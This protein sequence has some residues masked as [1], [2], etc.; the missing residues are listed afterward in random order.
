MIYTG[1]FTGRS[2]KD[3]FIVK[4]NI[5]RNTVDWN[6]T[7]MPILPMYYEQLRTKLIHYL[8][9]KEIYIRNAYACADEKYRLPLRLV[10]EYSWSA[11]F[12]NNMFLSPTT[13]EILNANP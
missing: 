13:N 12:A 10:D 5:T 4:D 3:R 8:E 6:K 2:P 9:D 11:M 1:T 7:N